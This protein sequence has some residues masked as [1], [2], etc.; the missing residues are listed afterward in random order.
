MGQGRQ[1]NPNTGHIPLTCRV[2]TSEPSVSQQD[3]STRKRKRFLNDIIPTIFVRHS[4]ESII[5][6]YIYIYIYMAA[7]QRHWVCNRLERSFPDIV[8]NRRGGCSAT[9]PAA[10]NPENKAQDWFIHRREKSATQGLNQPAATKACNTGTSETRALIH[11]HSHSHMYMYMYMYM[12]RYMY[13]YTC[14]CICVCIHICAQKPAF[15]LLLAGYASW[16][17]SA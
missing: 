13:M 12:Y 1:K 3:F 17:Q 5:S 14:I 15:A 9:N 10:T 8:F 6:G 16:Q 2:K 7:N 4:Q 11:S